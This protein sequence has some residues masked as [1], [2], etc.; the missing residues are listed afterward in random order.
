MIKFNQLNIS[1]HFWNHVI[2]ILFLKI[3]LFNS[4]EVSQSKSKLYYIITQRNIIQMIKKF[5][6]LKF[7]KKIVVNTTSNPSAILKPIT[8]GS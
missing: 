5:F 3:C 6:Q 2:T 1:A 8:L 4:N 7:E